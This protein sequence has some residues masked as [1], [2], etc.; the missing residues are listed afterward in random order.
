MPTMPLPAAACRFGR[1]QLTITL[2]TVGGVACFACGFADGKWVKVRQQPGRL[3]GWR[4]AA[5]ADVLRAPRLLLSSALFGIGTTDTGSATE[6][7]GDTW[8]DTVVEPK[9]VS[10]A[11][12]LMRSNGRVMNSCTMHQRQVRMSG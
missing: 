11:V 9:E 12:R 1:R 8:M 4:V 2:T 5:V 10:G 6:T 3:A 7:V